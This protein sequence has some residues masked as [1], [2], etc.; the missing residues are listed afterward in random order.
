MTV[1]IADA[2]KPDEIV[3]IM[4]LPDGGRLHPVAGK[5]RD[6][7][8]AAAQNQRGVP[9]YGAAPGSALRGSLPS[10]DRRSAPK[11]LRESPHL[12]SACYIGP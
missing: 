5:L 3:V 1:S 8:C 4:A 10:T 2:P 6:S 11:K 12:A 7:Q 9:L